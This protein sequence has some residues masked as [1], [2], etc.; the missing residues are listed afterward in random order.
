MAQVIEMPKLS[1][2]MEEGGIASWLKKEGDFVEEGEAFVEIETDKATMEYNSPLEGTLLKILVPAG[3]TTALNTPIAVIGEKGEKVDVAAL[4]KGGATPAPAAKEAPKASPA[5]AAKPGPATTA[6]VASAPAVSKAPTPSSSPSGRLRASPLAKKVAQDKGVDLQ[7]LQGSGPQ[8][9]VVIRDVE[10]FLQGGGKT[11]APAPAVARAPSPVFT[12]GVDQDIPVTMMRKTIA[13]RLLEGKNDAPHFYLTRSVNM[14]RLNEWRARINEE[15]EKSKGALAKV[16][17]NDLIILA[18]AKALRRHPQVNSSW[19]GDVIK[20]W[21]NV[22]VAV[23]V[24]LPQ[25]LITPVIRHTDQLGLREIAV[26]SKELI[27]RAKNGQLAPEDYTGGTF[28]ISNLGMMG[29]ESFTAIINPPQAA[30]LAVGATIPTPWVDEKNQVVVQ[31]RMTLT[32][33]CDHRV[34][35]GAVGAEFL[36]TLCSYLEDPLMMLS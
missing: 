21:G 23:A 34:V 32:M 12:A 25:G 3:K 30:I 17:V 8:G 16:S 18:T 6:K 35:D 31:P 10:A 13:K 28:T 19:Q 29:I 26:Q 22:N 9:R 33:S 5:P 7:Q 14:T 2:T 27:T 15:S 24:A 1:D 11:A 20:Q 4:T 36:Q